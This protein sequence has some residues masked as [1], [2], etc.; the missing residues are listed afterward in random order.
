MNKFTKLIQINEM[1]NGVSVN[2]KIQDLYNH[3]PTKMVSTHDPKITLSEQGHLIFAT[4]KKQSKRIVINN[5]LLALPAQYGF[6]KFDLIN[7]RNA[8][9]DISDVEV[10]HLPSSIIS[11]KYISIASSSL[12]S[13]SVDRIEFTLENTQAIPEFKIELDDDNLDF[14]MCSK[15]F[16]IVNNAPVILHIFLKE[17][18]APSIRNLDSIVRMRKY[19]NHIL[20]DSYDQLTWDTDGKMDTLN[21]AIEKYLRLGNANEFIDEIINAG[22]EEWL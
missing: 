4:N 21:D 6:D 16:K 2:E 9:I 3:L 7:T 1:D 17:N 22:M 14:N 8:F 19:I 15:L 18:V 5:T 20:F 12:S 10:K 11:S 13:S